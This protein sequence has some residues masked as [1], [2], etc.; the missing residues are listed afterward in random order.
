MRAL[1]EGPRWHYVALTLAALG[2]LLWALQSGIAASNGSIPR[3]VHDDYND[4]SQDR[5]WSETVDG[6][7][8]VIDSEDVIV[9]R[10]FDE[11]EITIP[12]CSVWADTSTPEL[13]EHTST[14]QCVGDD[15]VIVSA[16]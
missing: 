4:G 10:G 3:C 8:F 12:P 5:C 2:V 13:P 7:V 16:P 6:E 1:F 14:E 15:G 11:P 9:S